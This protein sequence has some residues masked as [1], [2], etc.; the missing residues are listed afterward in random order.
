MSSCVGPGAADYREELFDN[1]VF[2]RFS[3]ETHSIMCFEEEQKEIFSETIYK[4]AYDKNQQYIV[5]HLMS[6]KPLQDNKVV[7]YERLYNGEMEKVY[8]DK[9]LAY[10]CQEGVYH[11]FYSNF[12]LNVFLNENNI[13]INNWYYPS[14]GSSIKSEKKKLLGDFFVSN[15]RS[16]YSAISHNDDE[17]IYGFITDI[18]IDENQKTIEFRLRQKLYQYDEE[19]IGTV[20]I[21]LSELSQEPIG[22]F[23]QS[24]LNYEDVY[25]DKVIVLDTVTGEYFEKI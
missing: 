3:S 14:A 2:V 9:F 6:F 23:R 16:N 20:N 18:K 8:Y 13:K 19:V 11:E 5:V 12:D 17:I 15:I 24:F 1:Y 4:Y 25:Y 21:G 10:D 7:L 22:K